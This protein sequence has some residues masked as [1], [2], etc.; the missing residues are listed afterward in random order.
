MHMPNVR[1][2]LF[3]LLLS[4]YDLYLE[5][6]ENPNSP[7][8]QQILQSKPETWQ[9]SLYKFYFQTNRLYKK[10]IYYA[11]RFGELHIYKLVL[12]IMVLVAVLRVQTN[13]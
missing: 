4:I 11:W 10:F 12:F 2:L 3:V 9:E 5:N 8:S 1:F 13:I 6:T 7:Y